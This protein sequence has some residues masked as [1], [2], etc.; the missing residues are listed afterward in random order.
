LYQTAIVSGVLN[1]DAA[2]LDWFSPHL[3]ERARMLLAAEKSAPA[4]AGW[5]LVAPGDWTVNR[6]FVIPQ[7]YGLR[8]GPG[9]TLRFGQGGALVVYGPLLFEGKAESPILLTS[10][11][12]ADSWG[13]VG[14]MEAGAASEVRYT[15]VENTA[16]MAWPGWGTAMTGSFVFF[17]S[18]G[19]VAFAHFRRTRNT[20]EA[21]KFVSSPFEVLDTSFADV[22]FDAFDTD[23]SSGWLERCTF[24]NIGGDAIDF[25][26]TPAVVRRI[27][28]SDLDDKGVSLGE[29]SEAIIT[30]MTITRP[31]F[32]I[33]AKDGSRALAHDIKITA[34]VIAGLA[35][36]T[37]KPEFGSASLIAYN[38]EFDNAQHR[39]L[40]QTG[41][42]IDLDGERVWG[43]PVDVE[44][45][46][47]KFTRQVNA[48][49]G[50]VSP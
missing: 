1:L 17:K 19:R 27:V 3:I 5:F 12:D 25:S 29:G 39:T 9:T 30:D 32:G 11:A 35:A 2:S 42:W 18:P 34:P 8:I 20:N 46:Y 37:K 33:A 50:I 14:I 36:F 40:A 43:G 38:I 31:Y 47:L 13:G 15:I 22:E 48:R 7:G 16:G 23:F 41:H 4:P 45:I 10:A 24:H 44:E 49:R 21:L 28:A 26:T 6:N